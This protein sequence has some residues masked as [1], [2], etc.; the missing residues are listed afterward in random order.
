MRHSPA[1]ACQSTSQQCDV[2]A[3]DPHSRISANILECL[4]E[5]LGKAGRPSCAK[6]R[7]RAQSL[8]SS[9]TRE[10]ASLC[11]KSRRWQQA[12]PYNRNGNCAWYNFGCENSQRAFRRGQ[13]MLA[14]IW[15][16]I[17]EKSHHI[18]CV[19]FCKSC[20]LCETL[21]GS[22]WAGRR[23]VLPCCLSRS[24]VE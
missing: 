1:G 9:I 15:L 4:S 21:Y 20:T 3:A 14:Q 24:L 12:C 7:S 23:L 2:P 17:A 13:S 10:V 18:E 19:V 6:T 5:V 8:V 16:T 22:S 11:W